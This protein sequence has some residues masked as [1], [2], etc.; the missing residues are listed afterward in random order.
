MQFGLAQVRETYALSLRKG[1]ND[2]PQKF[3]EVLL[4]ESGASAET[5]LLEN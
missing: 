4:L 1:A 5:L 2:V 3:L